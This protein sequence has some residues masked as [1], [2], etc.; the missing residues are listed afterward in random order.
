MRKPLTS[1]RRLLIVLTTASL[2]IVRAA[3]IK[4][5]AKSKTAG[6]FKRKANEKKIPARRNL[7]CNPVKTPSVIGK[8][9]K[10]SPLNILPSINGVLVRSEKIIV[11][12]KATFSLKSF[13]CRRFQLYLR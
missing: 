10:I 8:I 13:L 3:K 11:A 5:A 4:K 9:I 7:R 2:L 6:T 12:T 1:L